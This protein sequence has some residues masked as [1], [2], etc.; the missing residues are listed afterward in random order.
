MLV[1]GVVAF[2]LFVFGL[3]GRVRCKEMALKDAANKG[4]L[5]AEVRSSWFETSMCG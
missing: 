3:G 4:L 1:L 2:R 5:P